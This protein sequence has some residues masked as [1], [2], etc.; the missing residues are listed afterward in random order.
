MINLERLNQAIAIMERAGNVYMGE[1]QVG[2]DVFDTEEELHSCGNSAC[3]AGWL[4]VSPEF[5]EAGGCPDYDGSPSLQ[6]KSPSETVAAW[7]ETDN[8][9]VVELLIY[10]EV[11][12]AKEVSTQF[13]ENHGIAHYRTANE[14]CIVL[15]DWEDYTAQ[16]VIKYLNALKDLSY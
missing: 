2:D 3:F 15:E 10:G 6:F 1:F 14:H 9:P 5:Q 11:G 16:D 12:N 13:L 7:L 8:L 4:A